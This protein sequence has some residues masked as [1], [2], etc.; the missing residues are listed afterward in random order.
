MKKIIIFTV[1]AIIAIIAGI[2]VGFNSEKDKEQ[3]TLAQN[4]ENNIV[5]NKVENKIENE[6][7]N[8]IDIENTVNTI[9]Q[10]EEEEPK[11]DLEKAIYIVKK[12]WGNDTTVYFAQDGKTN[13]N[14]YIICVRDKDTTEA[15]AWYTVNI[16]EET[17]VRE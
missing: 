3:E 4:I 10:E 9:E 17:F 2:I 6:I 15:L 11:T 5:Q 12:D 8:N 1:I 14:E 7:K 16:E 13:N